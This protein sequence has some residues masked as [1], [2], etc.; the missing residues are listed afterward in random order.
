VKPTVGVEAH[1]APAHGPDDALLLNGAQ[2]ICKKAVGG[3]FDAWI[4]FD[5]R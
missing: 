1:D 2:K 5:K 3:G 4:V